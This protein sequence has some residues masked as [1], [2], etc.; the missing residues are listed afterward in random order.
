MLW[1]LSDERERAVIE[2]AHFETPEKIAAR[3]E[4]FRALK[5]LLTSAHLGTS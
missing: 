1:A 3:R 5:D 2:S 4:R